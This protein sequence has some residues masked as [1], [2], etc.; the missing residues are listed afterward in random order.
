MTSGQ[1]VLLIVFAF[2][3]FLPTYVAWMR[4]ARGFWGVFVLNLFL[5]WTF[6]GWVVALA[7]AAVGSRDR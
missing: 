4:F 2:I 7:W 6:V 1:I 5:G 3:Y